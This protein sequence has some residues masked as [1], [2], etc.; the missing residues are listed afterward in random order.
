MSTG[1]ILESAMS[2][3]SRSAHAELL[4]RPDGAYSKL[5]EAQR[6][7]EAGAQDEL[8]LDSLDSDKH[9]LPSTSG[10]AVALTQAE[11]DELAKNEQPQFEQLKRIGT[12]RSAASVALEHR[13]A[14]LEAGGGREPV[15]Y[16]GLQLLVRMLK[17]NHARK[18]D[19]VIGILA[20]VVVGCGMLFPDCLNS[21]SGLLTSVL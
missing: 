19:Y 17:M 16:S 3:A 15:A 8:E 6:F 10:P 13:A 5:V 18:W 11:A 4:S 12:G 21:S 1:V 2:T 14:D 20:S 9:V 7:R